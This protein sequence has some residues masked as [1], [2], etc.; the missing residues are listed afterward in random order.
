MEINLGIEK[1]I[2]NAI[3]TRNITKSVNLYFKN[4]NAF[5]E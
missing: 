1:G 2:Y 5:Y 4:K 3:N